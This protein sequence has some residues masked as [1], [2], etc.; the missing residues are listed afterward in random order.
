[1]FSTSLAAVAVSGLVM[2]GSLATQP[3]WQSDYRIALTL[4]AEHQRPIAVF[5]GRG[6]TGYNRLIADG[7]FGPEAGKQLRQNYICLYVDSTTTT[8]QQLA[9]AFGMSEGLVI[10]D[11]TGGVQALRHEGTIPRADLGRYLEQYS[12]SNLTVQQ[13]TYA[14][15]AV[16]PAPVQTYQTPIYP[17]FSPYMGGFGGM[18]FG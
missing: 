4:A 18:S 16:Q 1:M 3:A 10:S 6:E 12:R 14:G 17:A 8:G 7:Q 9:G 11:K 13:T 5:I 15:R 2:S